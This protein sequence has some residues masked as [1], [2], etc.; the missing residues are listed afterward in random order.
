MIQQNRF[1]TKEVKNI[2]IIYRDNSSDI[3]QVVTHA[4]KWL[5]RKQLNTQ[6]FSQSSISKQAPIR[7]DVDLVLVLGGDGTYLKAVQCLPDHSVPFLGVN[8]G[9]FGF[10]TVHRQELIIHCLESTLKGKMAL[11]ER[12]LI[13]VSLQINKN[14]DN[15]FLAL[16][17]MV[18]ERGAFSHLINISISIQ[19]QNIYSLTADGVI[20]STPTGSTA[21]NLAAG[22]PI[23]HPQVNSFA[24]TPICSHSLT[25]RPVIF[26]DT[27]EMSFRINN[28]NQS[29]YLTIDGRKM[30]QISKEQP[31]QVKKSTMKHRT[32]RQ[33]EHNDFLLLKDKLKFSQ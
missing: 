9:S 19:D 32:L 21:Y 17:D 31:V 28:E 24:I 15:K 3:I 12:S 14:Q 13:D 4:E 10:L 23:L 8:M 1:F 25:N 7:F 5:K 6:V 33:T 2:L 18:I 29:A 20:I 11:E 26:P 27:Y 22:G 30:A 16:N